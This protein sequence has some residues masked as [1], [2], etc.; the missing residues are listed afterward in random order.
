MP[1]PRVLMESLLERRGERWRGAL[2]WAGGDASGAQKTGCPE[3]GVGRWG[4]VGGKTEWMS[5]DAGGRGR[6]GEPCNFCSQGFYFLSRI[7]RGCQL[8]VK[9][10]RRREAAV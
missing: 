10:R 3:I 4:L 2:E 8:R 6:G 9:W 1:H 7:G 5:T